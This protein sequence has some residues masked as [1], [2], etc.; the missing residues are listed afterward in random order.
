MDDEEQDN[1]F[2]DLRYQL[3]KKTEVL[4]KIL[5]TIEQ[6]PHINIDIDLMETS[7][8]GYVSF[9]LEVGNRDNEIVLP[10]HY[11]FVFRDTGTGIITFSLYEYTAEMNGFS[12]SEKKIGQ[13]PLEVGIFKIVEFFEE[14]V[15]KA[16]QSQTKI[17]LSFMIQMAKNRLADT[18]Q[19]RALA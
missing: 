19:K 4:Q 9:T 8:D 13:Y 16:L 18:A 7:Q 1:S 14:S 5:K 3:G 11:E 10:E 15:F 2:D 17:D 6:S 12:A